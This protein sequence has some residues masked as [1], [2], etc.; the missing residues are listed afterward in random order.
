GRDKAAVPASRQT[1]VRRTPMYRIVVVALAAFTLSVIPQ[2]GEAAETA[3]AKGAGT[4][5]LA[6]SETRAPRAASGKRR[7]AA[8]AAATAKQPAPPSTWRGAD[9]TRGPGTDYM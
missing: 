4:L 7:A 3:R 1:G 2:A 8:P 9:P 6:Q 5:T